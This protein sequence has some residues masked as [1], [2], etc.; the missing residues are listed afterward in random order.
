LLGRLDKRSESERGVAMW[1]VIG[2]RTGR[3]DHGNLT[4]SISCRQHYDTSISL[5]LSHQHVSEE[6]AGY[7]R[8]ENTRDIHAIQTANDATFPE[9]EGLLRPTRMASVRVHEA[10]RRSGINSSYLLP[11]LIVRDG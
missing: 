9:A 5:Q 10:K 1:A 2:E 3:S 7:P 11:P 8:P 4:S 6:R